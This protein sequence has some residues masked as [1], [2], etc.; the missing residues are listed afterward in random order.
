MNK[1]IESLH[2]KIIDQL[3]Y[4]FSSNEILNVFLSMSNSYEKSLE[5][6]KNSPKEN[7]EQKPTES[8]GDNLENKDVNLENKDVKLENEDVKLE[9]EEQ[10]EDVKLENEDVK[11]ENKEQ[12]EDV[13][14][15]KQIPNENDPILNEINEMKIREIQQL[16]KKIKILFLILEDLLKLKI[17]KVNEDRY[18]KVLDEKIK[19]PKNI[20]SLIIIMGCYSEA[21]D[22]EYQSIILNIIDLPFFNDMVSIADIHVNMIPFVANDKINL[23]SLKTDFNSFSLMVRNLACDILEVNTDFTKES[24]I[25]TIPI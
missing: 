14:P 15:E 5:I 2:T 8:D 16:F 25:E 19:F 23:F 3:K 9:N 4:I 21:F 7:A 6:V 17:I 10:K 13:K 1:S 22:Y 11:L 12:K 24:M 20:D 18:R